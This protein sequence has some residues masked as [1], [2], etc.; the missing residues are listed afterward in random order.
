MKTKD[1]IPDPKLRAALALLLGTPGEP[2][3]DALGTRQTNVDFGHVLG[4]NAQ[5]F[6]PGRSGEQSDRIVVSDELRF[7]DAA[8]LAPVLFYESLHIDDLIGR[9]EV[10]TLIFASELIHA[11]LLAEDLRVSSVNSELARDLRTSL[12][13]VVFNSRTPLRS[14]GELFPEGPYASNVYSGSGYV[15]LA[16]GET[17]GNEYLLQTLQM[18]GLELNDAPTYSIELLEQL[19]IAT[20]IDSPESRLTADDLIVIAARN[21][22]ALD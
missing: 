13:A 20:I 7:E 5:R 14:R 21:S 11:Q 19:D 9:E 15:T 1:R 16:E 3:I 6:L 22:I 10:V 17:P 2:G 12:L 18:L 8:L 4:G